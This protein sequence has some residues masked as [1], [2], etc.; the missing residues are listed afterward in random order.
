MYRQLTPEEISKLPQAR[1]PTPVYLVPREVSVKDAA[2]AIS[3]ARLVGFDTETKPA[4]KA[5]QKFPPALIQLA[6]PEAAYLFQMR[7]VK[8]TASVKKILTAPNLKIG[9]GIPED[10]RR[11]QA[12]FNISFGKNF[13][14]LTALAKAR[15]IPVGSLR[16]LCATL[17]GKRLS[18]AAQLT[19]W[20]RID[21]NQAQISYAALDAW[22]SLGIYEKLC[23]L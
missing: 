8:D 20:A 18:K 7:L 5:G 4:F 11:L 16:G 9:V 2:Q 19:N 22:I 23:E 3:R 13:C 21:L 1:C 15:G 17:L 12:Y 10:L 14:D 6:T